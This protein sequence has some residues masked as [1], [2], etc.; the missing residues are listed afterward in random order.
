M[1]ATKAHTAQ[2]FSPWSIARTTW[3]GK[4]TLILVWAGVTVAGAILVRSLPAV[5]TSQAL[6]L[7][8]SQK[9]PERFVVSTV[10]SELQDRVASISEQ[11]LSSNQLNRIINDLGLYKAERKSMP[12]EAIVE[13]MRKDIE[14]KA[15]KQGFAKNKP[16]AFRIS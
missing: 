16:G 10:S 11:I 1:S 6:I 5:Y 13:R 8:D 2:P 14:I 12:Q 4:W 7:V 3:K 15:E 9:I